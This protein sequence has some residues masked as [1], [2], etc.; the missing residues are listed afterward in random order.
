MSVQAVTK[1]HRPSYLNNKNLVF[2]VLESGRPRSG[3]Q[4]GQ[5]L[6]KALFL[7]CRQLPS[8]CVLKMADRE[9]EREREGE[10]AS[11]LVSFLIR[12]LISS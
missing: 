9:I 8:N 4:H 3:C 12:A 2:T 10:A 11:S 1:C 7:V 6:V 5:I